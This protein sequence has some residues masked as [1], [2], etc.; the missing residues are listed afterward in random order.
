M[1][2]GNRGIETIN[3]SG[4]GDYTLEGAVDGYQ[5]LKAAAIELTGDTVGPWEL[6]LTV[7]DDTDSETGIYT[8]TDGAPGKDTLS[9]D[10]IE[11]STNGDAAVNWGSNTKTVRICPSARSL[12]TLPGY[13]KESELTISGGAVTAR[14]ALHSIDTESDAATDDLDS[15]ATTYLREGRELLIRAAN[16]ARTVVVKDA[17]GGAGQIH[18]ADNADFSLDDTDKWLRLVRLGA[19]WYELGRSWGADVAAARAFYGVT[20][21]SNLLKPVL[22][23]PGQI[24]QEVV[25]EDATADSTTSNNFSDTSLSGTITPLFDDSVIEISVMVYATVSNTSGS[26]EGTRRGEFVINDDTAGAQVGSGYPFGRALVAGNTSGAEGNHPIHIVERK[27][28]ADTNARTFT[29]RFRMIDGTP[30]NVTVTTPSTV[31]KR[32]VIREIKQ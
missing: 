6:E 3:T 25:A 15:I 5:T 27:T 7:S 20:D 19:D 31:N 29:L 30:G 10:S 1:T 26:S 9:R 18:L 4:T 12:A 23:R 14:F 28:V 17:A 16:A 32:M 11:S 21:G 13:A 22:F 24:V 2:L 8:L